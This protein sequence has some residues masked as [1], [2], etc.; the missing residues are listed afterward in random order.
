MGKSLCY[1]LCILDLARPRCSGYRLGW[2]G[3]WF[4]N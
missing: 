3:V 2:C 4:L 1:L